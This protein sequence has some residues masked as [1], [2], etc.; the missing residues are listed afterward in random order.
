MDKIKD[1]QAKLSKAEEEKNEALYG[2]ATIDAIL[3]GDTAPTKDMR[4][5]SVQTEKARKLQEEI[6]RLMLGFEDAQKC[7]KLLANAVFDEE[8]ECW[9]TC[10]ADV[11]YARKT[12]SQMAKLALNQG[13][14]K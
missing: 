3:D 6:K 1:L 9:Y 5:Y 2:I 7:T 13:E 11:L 4:G 10:E 12:L 8:E 14:N